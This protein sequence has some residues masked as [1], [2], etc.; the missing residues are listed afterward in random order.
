MPNSDAYSPVWTELI[1]QHAMDEGAFFPALPE[2]EEMEAM[3]AF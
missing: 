1:I 2:P 3:E